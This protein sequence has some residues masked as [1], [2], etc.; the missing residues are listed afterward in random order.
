MTHPILQLFSAKTNSIHAHGTSLNL[1]LQTELA[2]TMGNKELKEHIDYIVKRL[3]SC[4]MQPS[5]DSPL[6]SFFISQAF[7][8]LISE[9]ETFLVDVMSIIIRKF[10]LKLG[11]ETFKLSEILEFAN[12]DEIARVA[13][14]RHI[15]SIMYKKANEYRKS[16]ADILSAEATFLEMEW[17]KYVESKARRDLGVHNGWL[18]N[19][20]YL[21]KVSEAGM[22]STI[23]G[24]AVPSNDYFWACLDLIS[25]LMGKITR[26]AIVKFPDIN[27]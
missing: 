7:V 1:L 8:S 4:Y 14:E 25:E 22:E 9:F 10:P 27:T 24:S 5:G 13:A 18:V 20:T 21:R 16:L 6:Q 19:E 26:H 12:M 23:Q 15:N 3:P 2:S 17:P 11:A